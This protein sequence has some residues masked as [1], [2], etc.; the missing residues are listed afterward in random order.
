M[1][2]LNY[3]TSI[4]TEKT[5][6]EIQMKL[7][8]AGASAVMSE[9]DENGIMNAMS[10]RINTFYFRLPINIDG[11]YQVMKRDKKIMPKL[12]TYEQAARVAW[13]IIKDWVEAQIAIIE[14]RQAELTQVFFPYL[15][16]QTGQ[17]LY[18]IAKESEF[19]NL[20]PLPKDKEIIK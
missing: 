10:F 1:T 17:T 14:A 13:R 4:S 3:T 2:I 20:L 6:G 8:K 16:N 19:N 7:A 12:K 5:A 11:V 9:Y 15:Q 18:Q